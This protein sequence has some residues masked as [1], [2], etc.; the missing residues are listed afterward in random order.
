MSL[1]NEV[2]E[3]QHDP[4]QSWW[5]VLMFT[6]A[7]IPSTCATVHAWGNK[8]RCVFCAQERTPPFTKT[9][10]FTCIILLTF[11]AASGYALVLPSLW[12][13]MEHLGAGHSAYSVSAACFSM[14]ALTGMLILG[15]L[16]DYCAPKPI[17]LVATGLLSVPRHPGS[18]CFF[19]SLPTHC[20]VANA[21]SYLPT[22]Q[23]NTTTQTQNE[24]YAHTPSD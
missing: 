9:L 17:L 1:F 7:V 4:S 23:H 3:N 11:A 22:T 14:G 16:A 13:L 21:I 2:E 8:V 19:G 12:P 24:P 18:A 6:L 15:V 10:T 5:Q 20:I